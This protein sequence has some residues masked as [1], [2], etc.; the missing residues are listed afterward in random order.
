MKVAI[1]QKTL[2]LLRGALWKHPCE[3]NISAKEWTEIMHFA[4]EQA[5]DGVVPDAWVL[6]PKEE[7]PE[8]SAKMHMVVRQLQV[9]NAN[10]RMNKELLS[11]VKGLDRREIPYA[12]LK[13]QGV[14]TLYPNP[15]HRVSGDI[16]LYV[17]I[18]F[19]KEVNRGMVAYGGV[20]I[21]ETRHHVNY[22]AHGV[23][24]ELHHSIYYFQKE[25]RNR[26]F[27]NYVDEAMAQP[28]AYASIG[29]EKVRVLPSTMN[30]LTLLSHIL[31]HFYC[32][33]IGLR[34]LCD[35]ALLLDK[36]YDNINRVQLNKALKELS[37]LR[38]Y[39]VWGFLCVHYLG[40]SFDKLMFEPTE[41]DKRLAH[42]IMN[43]CLR[44][45]NFG[46]SEAPKRDT[47][48]N[49]IRYYIRFLFRLLRYWRLCPSEA[50]WWPLAK[51]KRFF[52]GTV[53]LSEEKSVL[54]VE[55][56]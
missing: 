20:K 12:L 17:P 29:D 6:L 21:C 2:A 14:A 43:D 22:K 19:Y 5:V 28:V 39:R 55:R 49:W 34:Q 9:E 11:F 25:S 3:V 31:D 38:T 7:R 15:R 26:L 35:Y 16:D 33:G 46:R 4:T 51:L 41:S 50:L 1:Y 36:E 40:L 10:L 52:T 42:R 30:V 54:N 45:G 18:Q 24:W 56:I 47:P 32:S 53:H 27:M 13:G 37:L 48:C 8:M 44:G 23:V